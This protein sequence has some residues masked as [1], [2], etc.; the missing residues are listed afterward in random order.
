MIQLRDTENRCIY[1]NEK[2]I[3]HFRRNTYDE[4]TVVELR[5]SRVFTLERPE[6]IMKKILEEAAK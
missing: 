5:N 1:V 6:E 4:Y 2:E 3:Q